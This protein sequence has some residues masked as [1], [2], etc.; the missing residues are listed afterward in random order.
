M[1]NGI[2]LRPLPFPDSDR[3]MRVWE[4][5]ER[6]NTMSVAWPNL[7]D[8]QEE[9]ASFES[10]AGYTSQTATVLGI[11]RPVR[12]GFSTV[13]RG[14]FDALGVSP[15]VG[16]TFLPEEQVEGAEPTVVVSHAFWR[17]HL[18]GRRDLS[19]LRLELGGVSPRV[20]GVMPPGFEF[21]AGAEIWTPAELAPTGRDRT[22]HNYRVIARLADGTSLERAREEVGA[23]T[24]RA[25]EGLSGPYYA[26]GV[27]VLP[28][29]ED[30]V[31]PVERPLLL[32]LGAAGL[33]LLVACTNLASTFMARALSRGR[34]IAVRRSL[35]AGRARVIRQLLTEA[36]LL[37]LIGGA[38]G[39]ALTLGLVRAMLGLAPAGIPRL[40]GV[41]VDG[42]VLAF[43]F[44][45]SVATALLFGL[46]PAFRSS[47]LDAAEA[48]R[49]G[50]RE[51][52]GGRR[53]RFW[54]FLVGGEVALALVLVVGSGL[55]SRSFL[56]VMS[57]DPGFRTEGV[58]TV[59]I[60]L[61][62]SRYADDPSQ[63]RFFERAFEEI[64]SLPAVDAV[65]VISHLPLRGFNP[66][67]L[68]TV[69]DGP[70]E[71]LD[72]AAYRVASRGYFAAMGIPLIRGRLF[73]DTDDASVPDV[74]VV[75]E[76]FA[77]RAWPG[78]NP[79][80]KRMTSGGMDAYADTARGLSPEGYPYPRTATVIG[81]VEDVR[82]AGLTSSVEPT[83]Y[84]HVRQRPARARTGTLVVR[85]QAGV[86]A[87]A[88]P[89]RGQLRELDPDVPLRLGTMEEVVRTSVAARRFT[90][91]VL[92][93][94]GAVALLL[95]GIGIY[96]V[97]SYS[98]ARRTGEM[99]IRIALGAE[100]P[101]V[102]RLVQGA[103]LRTVALGGVVGVAGAVA[104]SRVVQRL[105]YEVSPLDPAVYAGGAGLLVAVAWLASWVPARRTT[106]IDP[107]RTMRAE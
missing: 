94:F 33:L 63:V 70:M 3:L 74:V 64:G 60:S 75:S 59:S 43:A 104:L 54:P 22:A 65:G 98:V 68:A 14:F 35:G 88:G 23:V 107:V 80:G 69:E 71:Q 52:S 15:A 32:L 51:S 56:R 73:E 57:V 6:S 61:P 25:L 97:V 81:V 101:A 58:A 26:A 47:D 24:R 45:V 106:R 2:L 19:A 21:P 1:V 30:L 92:G 105:L 13:S 67:G 93:A 77:E 39:L 48:L 76:A 29:Q 44:G 4:V 66:T 85:S 100:P 95:A 42:P 96:G 46:F 8:W 102:R 12:A 41:T 50:A 7:R 27:E 20:V 11:E 38:L 78:E 16:R 89:V 86:G 17:D 18:G 72:D 31:G 34:E 49:S 10:V 91:A 55:L 37:A 40:D 53:D 84:V 9:V 28:L 90:V 82:H 36:L 87:V 62:P 83:Y 103:T 99:G 79:I 5:S